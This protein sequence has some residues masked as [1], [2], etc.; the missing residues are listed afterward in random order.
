MR[1][2]VSGG[3]AVGRGAAEQDAANRPGDN[4]AVN[5]KRRSTASDSAHA[6]TIA[7]P[8]VSAR[9]TQSAAKTTFASVSFAPLLG[10]SQVSKDSASGTPMQVATIAA[11]R[12][13]LRL[14]FAV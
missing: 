9:P 8:A 5:R 1:R 12:S 4:G 6:M 10:W 13:R 2:A 14:T 3:L 11:A 7:V